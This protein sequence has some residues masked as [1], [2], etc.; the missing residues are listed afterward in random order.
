[1]TTTAPGHLSTLLAP[2]PALL[3]FSLRLDAVV[4]AANGLAYLA[5]SGPIESLLGLDTAVGIPVGIFL[6]LYGIGVALVGAQANINSAAV[7]VV[8][9]GNAAWVVLSLVAL[10]AAGLDLTVVGAIWA[11]LQAITV[12]GFAVLQYVGLK[13]A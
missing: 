3:R 5:L 6:L 13:R 7:R 12:G 10:A 8:I 4:T 2:G 9:A 1:M 11:V